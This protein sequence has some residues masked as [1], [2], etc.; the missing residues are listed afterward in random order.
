MAKSQQKGNCVPSVHTWKALTSLSVSST[1]RPTG[2]SLTVFWRRVPSGAMMN[3]PLHATATL[4]AMSYQIRG[5]LSKCRM[6]HGCASAQADPANTSTGKWYQTMQA[7]A[8]MAKHHNAVHADGNATPLVLH[9][10]QCALQ[11]RLARVDRHLL[12][13]ALGSPQ[14]HACIWP[15]LNQHLIVP[16]NLHGINMRACW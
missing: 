3:R 11:A 5:Q 13:P 15:I 6:H 4:S 1:L 10:A 8:N 9:V 2:R 14:C 7:M 12:A 16:G